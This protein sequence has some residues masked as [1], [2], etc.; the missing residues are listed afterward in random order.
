MFAVLFTPYLLTAW[1]VGVSW[2]TD[3][4]RPKRG[5][6]DRSLSLSFLVRCA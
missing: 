2:S 1:A 6:A 3:F 5:A 4:R